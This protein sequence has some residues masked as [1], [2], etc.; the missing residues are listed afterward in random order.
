MKWWKESAILFLLLC[1]TSIPKLC[2]ENENK[3]I[4]LSWLEKPSKCYPPKP[5]SLARPFKGVWV[6]VVWKKKS[7]LMNINNWKG[8]SAK[9][10]ITSFLNRPQLCMQLSVEHLKPYEAEGTTRGR[11]FS[12]ASQR[13]VHRCR[14]ASAPGLSRALPF[15]PLTG[16]SSC[17]QPYLS[18]SGTPTGPSIPSL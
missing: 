15:H 13:T 11:C 7:T 3:P 18:N 17:F 10:P 4:M 5:H 1:F 16:P 6:F 9:S 2:S 8:I 14:P 12:P